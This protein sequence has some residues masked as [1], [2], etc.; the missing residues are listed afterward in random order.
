MTIAGLFWLWNIKILIIIAT[1][2]SFKVRFLIYFSKIL[3][4]SL[5]RLLFIRPGE[6]RF[7]VLW[8]IKLI[9]IRELILSSW[10][11]FGTRKLFLLL[12]LLLFFYD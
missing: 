8:S 5:P 1:F 2:E 12:L 6:I 7:I 9:Y 3:P 10:L 4:S 11:R